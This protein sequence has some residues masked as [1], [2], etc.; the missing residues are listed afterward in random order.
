M[1]SKIFKIE[2]PYSIH[3]FLAFFFQDLTDDDA[4]GIVFVLLPLLRHR[5]L[6]IKFNITYTG[7]R[8]NG[9]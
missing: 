5:L 6:D 2:Y 1:Q 4:K 3:I 7:F 8:H 9:G